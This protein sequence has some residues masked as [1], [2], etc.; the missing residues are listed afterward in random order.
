[1]MVVDAG[2]SVCGCD[3][4]LARKN[5]VFLSPELAKS[6]ESCGELA[7]VER[8]GGWKMVSLRVVGLA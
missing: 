5:A 3:L 4:K 7:V 2:D 6:C 8:V 1:M